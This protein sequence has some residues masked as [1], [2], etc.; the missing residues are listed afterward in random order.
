MAW[1]GQPG[2]V[3]DCGRQGAS[4]PAAGEATSAGRSASS[5]PVGRHTAGAVTQGG[6][7]GAHF[8]V[9]SGRAR[10]VLLAAPLAPALQPRPLLPQEAQGQPAR[11]ACTCTW[12]ARPQV[13]QA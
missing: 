8:G 3:D 9:G 7:P 5:M 11:L 2:L 4:R 6:H 10:L 12:W 13:S 1:A